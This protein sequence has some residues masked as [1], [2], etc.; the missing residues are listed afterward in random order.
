MNGV[1]EISITAVA[2][3]S[4]AAGVVEILERK[5]IDHPDTICDA[6]A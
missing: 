4:P 6:L 3:P 2:I 5:G 1:A